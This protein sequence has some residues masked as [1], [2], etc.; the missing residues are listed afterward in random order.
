M[1]LG[2]L[3]GFMDIRYDDKNRLMVVS[4]LQEV[5]NKGSKGKREER[6][7]PYL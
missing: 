6:I 3:P 2:D 7:N 5:L 1:F 4:E